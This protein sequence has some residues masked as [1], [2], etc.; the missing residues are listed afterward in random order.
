LNKENNY[1]DV[2]FI[3]QPNCGKS[4]LFNAIAGL[5]ADTSNFPGTSIQHTHSK[6]NVEGNI[7]NIIDLPG[8]YSLN[9]SDP[10]EKVAL[11]HL[12][13]EKPDLIINVIDASILGRSLELTLELIEL[14]YPVIVALNMMDLAEKKG[15]EID[16]NKLEK[17]IGIPVIPTT[18]T[19][20]RGIKELLDAVLQGLEKGLSVSSIKWSRDVEQ[21]IEELTKI[22]PD[23]FPFISNKRFTAI[24]MIEANK[25][26]FDEVLK[27]IN[28]PLKKALDR[29]RHD[30]ETMHNAPAYEV[31]SAE[32]HHL[33]FKIFEECS[34]VKR[35]KRI[36]FE[37]KIDDIIMHPFFGYLIFLAI[38]FGFFFVIFKIGSPLEEL[39]LEPLTN[40]RHSLALSLGKGVLFYLIDGLLAGIGGG[41]AIVLPYFLPLIF[42]MSFLEDVGYLARA[43]FLMDTFM[44]KI[45]LHGKSISPF[46]LGFGCN[47]PAIVNTRTL[48][49]RRDR[50]ITSL[51]IP[52]IPCSARTTIILALVAFYLGPLWALG[53]YVFNILLVAILGRVI[54]FFFRTPSPGL[55]LEIPS[56]KTPSLKNMLKKTFF[57]MKS[58]IKFAW[59]ILIVGSIILGFLQYLHLDRYINL[60]LSPLVEKGLGLPR[61]LGVTLVFG[62]LRK[63]L[64]LVMMLQ[65]LDVNYKDVMTVITK[66]QLVVFTV[67][68]NFFV[69]CLSTV[70]LLWK[71][72]GKRVALISIGLN[73]GVAVIL[74]LIARLILRR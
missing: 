40:L 15:I 32:R 71:E 73:T 63:E 46:I 10:A 55:I 74:S 4:T 17:L 23:D 48:E 70:A 22:L 72:I 34:R 60:V 59:P 68:I 21:K 26:F 53:F 45:G 28:P 1:S 35:G 69:P 66:E 27:D 25:L 43:G 5:K 58:F 12:F 67:F 13:H 50:V 16:K 24:H 3:G 42:L 31:I 9:P 56:L 52:F 2:I 8:T 14:G 39:L 41:V 7:L 62:F 6:V 33:A 54:T 49:S 65:A 37:E 61:E 20:G 11:T 64:S 18:A 47:V 19:H 51:L 30:L 57:Q 36:S 44:H 29:I 38:F